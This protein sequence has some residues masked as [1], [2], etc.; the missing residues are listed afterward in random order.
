VTQEPRASRLWSE[1]P[2]RQRPV[3][4]ARR[5]GPHGLPGV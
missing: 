1:V 3:R 5:L 2:A 4:A